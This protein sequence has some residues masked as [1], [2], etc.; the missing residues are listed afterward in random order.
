MTPSCSGTSVAAFR[1]D[2]SRA[3]VEVPVELKQLAKVRTQ[4]IAPTRRG[5]SMCSLRACERHVPL[6]YYRRFHH[7]LI[8]S[9]TIRAI[10]E[11]M[12][13]LPPPF[14]PSLPPSTFSNP[15]SLFLSLLLFPL[16]PFRSFRSQGGC[17]L[18]LCAHLPHHGGSHSKVQVSAAAV[19]AALLLTHCTAPRNPDGA[20]QG[21]TAHNM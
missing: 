13:A 7:F 9:I 3:L 6:L 16:S 1:P 10:P 19:T 5:R 18:V 17:A 14:P 15:F 12:R 2:M 11:T 21:R 8:L 4:H 20:Q